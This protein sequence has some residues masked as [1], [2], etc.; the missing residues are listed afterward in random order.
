MPLFTGNF[1][2]LLAPGLRQIFN[3]TL[4]TTPEE[5]PHVFNM[6]GTKRAYEEDLKVA[7]FG[8]MGEKPQGQSIAYDDPV[9][10]G[11]VR[12]T[13]VT[14]GMGFRVTLE[15]WEDDLYGVIRKYPRELAISA[16]QTREVRGWRLL[17]NAFGT[18]YFTGFD[19]LQLCSTAHTLLKSGGTAAN[20]A[21]TDLDLGVTSLEEAL[22]NFQDLVNDSGFPVGGLYKPKYLV[23]PTALEFLAT[24]IVGSQYEPFT[25]DNQINEL[26]RRGLQVIVSHFLTDADAWFVIADRHD[27]NWFTRSAIRFDNSDDFDTKDAKFSAFERYIQGFG[28]WRGVFGSAGA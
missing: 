19:T 17:N 24:K 6:L 4:K 12:Y 2:E 28:D 15:M 9:Q 7:G 22:T 5:Y 1:S 18:T 16:K 10:G 8:A 13:A 27:M 23:V 21:T 26:S 25:A 11:K 20:R 3:A 14:F